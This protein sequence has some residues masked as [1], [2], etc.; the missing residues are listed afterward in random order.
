MR[1]FIQWSLVTVVAIV[2]LAAMVGQ[3]LATTTGRAR[4]A[5]VAVLKEKLARLEAERAAAAP[6][7]VF[8]VAPG[9]GSDS[10]HTAMDEDALRARWNA[11]FETF[12]DENGSCGI[13]EDVL[14]A[15]TRSAID[16]DA[17]ALEA[18][19]R[20]AL[21][22]YQTCVEPAMNELQTLRDS[23]PELE[24]LF[25]VN[26]LHYDDRLLR[27]YWELQ[28]RLWIE[29]ALGDSEGLIDAFTS[30]SYLKNS[31]LGLDF[32]SPYAFPS[33][34]WILLKRAVESQVVDDARWNRLLEVL[35]PSRS[36]RR[37]EELIHRKAA[38][39]S[40]EFETWAAAPPS[41]KFS[42]AP[43][44]YLRSWA[45]P[46][47]TPAL[48]N[49]DFDRFNR[50]MNE[51]LDLVD[52]PY[53][54][55]K[56]ELEQFCRDFDVEPSRRDIKF[57]RENPGWRFVVKLS[58]H[59]IKAHARRQA[60]VDVIRVAI[61]L[62]RHRRDT[63]SYPDSLDA[64]SEAFDGSLPVNPLMGDMYVYERL[65]DSFRLGFREEMDANLVELGHGP[66]MV[67]W[68][69]EPRVSEE[70]EIVE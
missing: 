6:V 38:S 23:E 29:A 53:F 15:T 18:E 27:L 63:G 36:Q 19:A 68:W 34:D 61:L 10:S 17:H 65:D 69:H 67:T 44:S 37:F 41:F 2:L 28:R 46:R 30:Q 9:A 47:L 24:A 20:D 70:E 58:R 62:E 50:A 3:M 64:L 25:E 51:L 54:E 26:D 4:D 14:N 49:H 42:D 48:F 60:F 12:T 22:E 21:L 45:Y 52:N 7:A 1:K 39:I 16:P 13:S 5:S 32:R 33:T 55:V 11:L 66:T 40:K 43:V 59:E 31:V 56:D 8:D 35:E 57:T